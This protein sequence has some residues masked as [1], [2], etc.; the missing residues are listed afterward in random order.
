MHRPVHQP[1]PMHLAAWL[2]P[3]DLVALV[4]DIEYLC[5]HY[6]GRPLQI[7]GETG[8]LSQGDLLRADL[9]GEL[10]TL[11]FLGQPLLRPVPLEQ[12]EHHL[13]PLG[14]TAFHYPHIRLALLVRKRGRLAAHQ[15]DAGRIN[16]RLREKTTGRDLEPGLR[17]VIELD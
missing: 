12:L 1:Q 10:E 11:K 5:A 3:N 17:L 7:S 4:D 13:P 6:G 2:L 16:V 14:E 9:A 15:A 8:E